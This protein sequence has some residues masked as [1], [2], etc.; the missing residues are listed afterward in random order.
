MRSARF[1]QVRP[2]PP[3]LR[4]LRSLCILVINPARP[5]VRASVWKAASEGTVGLGEGLCFKLSRL[6]TSEKQSLPHT[7]ATRRFC[8]RIC[9]TCICPPVAVKLK[10]ICGR[11]GYKA[12]VTPLLQTFIAVPLKNGDVTRNVLIFLIQG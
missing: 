8:V 12:V 4:A 11:R 5:R 3:A 10:L 6:G 1:N 2:P 9:K 7:S